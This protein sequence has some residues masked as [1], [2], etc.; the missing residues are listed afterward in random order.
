LNFDCTLVA[1]LHSDEGFVVLFPCK[2][3]LKGCRARSEE[4]F[5]GGIE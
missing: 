4:F 5:F 3:R 2:W 1:A